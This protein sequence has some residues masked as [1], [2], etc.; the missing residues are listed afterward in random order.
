ME[1]WE[2]VSERGTAGTFGTFGATGTLGT[3]GTK[4]RESDFE[5]LNV[6]PLNRR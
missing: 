3:Y 1:N 2:A 5:L 6:E 4:P